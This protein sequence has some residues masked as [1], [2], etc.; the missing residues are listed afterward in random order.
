MREE[1][2]SIEK[3]KEQKGGDGLKKKKKKNL[4]RKSN[5]PNFPQS[6][7]NCPQGS[8][9]LMI[10]FSSLSKTLPQE[11]SRDSHSS[12]YF[13]EHQA[14]IPLILPVTLLYLFISFYYTE[15]LRARVMSNLQCSS[16]L[17]HTGGTPRLNELI[18]SH[19]LGTG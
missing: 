1:T 9:S 7:C 3:A 14:N 4:G 6:L 18:R 11:H 19:P 8:S 17:A 15:S 12:C 16:I 13:S 2:Q 5:H 10:N